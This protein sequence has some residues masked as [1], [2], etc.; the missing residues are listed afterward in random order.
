MKSLVQLEKGKTGIVIE[1]KGGHNFIYKMDALGIRPGV[2]IKKTSEINVSGPVIVEIGNTKM[3][4]GKK[5]AQK[6]II[7]EL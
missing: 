6:I 2:K 3:A 4:I 7:K 1:L 5:M